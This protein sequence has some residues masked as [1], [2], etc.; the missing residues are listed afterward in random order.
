MLVSPRPVRWLVLTDS[1]PGPRWG[2]VLEAGGTA[3]MP[4]TSGVD[5]LVAAIRSVVAR[6]PAM[7][8]D[9]RDRVLEEWR[10]VAPEQRELVAR[11]EQLTP[12]ETQVLS[13]LYDGTG[14]G[15]I[16]TLSGTSVSTVRSQVK[17]IRLKLHAESQLAAVAMY[18]RA[19]EI[20]PRHPR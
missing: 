14:V 17:A 6:G 2:C 19:L 18:R 13:M 3:V 12:R 15:R 16:A 4:T 10:S 20:F 5:T 7:P 8:D 1:D 9:L 11:M